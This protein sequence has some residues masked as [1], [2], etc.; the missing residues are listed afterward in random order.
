MLLAL[1]ISFLSRGRTAI[2]LRG[3]RSSRRGSPQARE[4]CQDLERRPS[5]DHLG[6]GADCFPVATGRWPLDPPA[7]YQLEAPADLV[8]GQ[9]GARLAK[10]PGPEQIENDHWRQ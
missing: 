2:N 7:D 4:L 5:M 3:W 9:P 6:A 10:A 1:G 8:M